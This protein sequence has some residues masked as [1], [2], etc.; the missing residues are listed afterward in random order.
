VTE[1]SA[2]FM[3]R[4]FFSHRPTGA[5]LGAGRALALD[6]SRRNGAGAAGGGFFFGAQGAGVSGF[7]GLFCGV[8]GC[9]VPL[10]YDKRIPLFV[11]VSR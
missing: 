2:G 6:S 1:F 5:L 3:V 8:H 11:E 4:S 10:K 9:S 7:L